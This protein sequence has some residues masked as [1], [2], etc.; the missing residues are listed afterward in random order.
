[1]SARES[2]TKILGEW[3]AGDAGAR[4]R[5]FPLIYDELRRLAGG[6]LRRERPNH[7]LQPT[8]LAHEAVLRLWDQ[9]NAP[10]RGRQEL[11]GAVAQMMRRVLVD[12]ARRQRSARRGGG[13]T[14]VTF[15]EGVGQ[16]SSKE[17][18]LLHLD[19]AISKLVELDPRQA[20]VV[21][22]RVFGGFEVK[23][24]A[25]ILSISEATVKR[26]WRI[27]RAWLYRELYG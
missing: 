21:E 4:E 27:A 10:G 18:D 9:R 15:V 22:L 5:L 16:A 12:H 14:M 7:T 24:V 23:E 1:M 2:V 11:M 20:S 26:E 25:E 6:F 8:A 13:R 17:V 19:L 3:E